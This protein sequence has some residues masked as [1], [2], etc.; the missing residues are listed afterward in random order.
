MCGGLV[1]WLV[2]VFSGGDEDDGVHQSLM[3]I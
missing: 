1:G 2:G 3:M